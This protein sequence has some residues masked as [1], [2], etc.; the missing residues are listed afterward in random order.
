MLFGAVILT[1]T[2]TV[3]VFITAFLVGLTIVMLGSR[4]SD[5]AANVGKVVNIRQIMT[6]KTMRTLL[7]PTIAAPF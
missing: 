1:D 3:P 4:G 5:V 2:K 7:L 6:V